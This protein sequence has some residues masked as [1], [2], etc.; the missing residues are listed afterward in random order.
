MLEQKDEIDDIDYNIKL[1]KERLIEKVPTHFSLQNVVDA[2]FA[3]LL[4]GLTFILKGALVRTALSLTSWHILAVVVFTF[5]IL[6]IQIYFISYQR[7]KNKEERSFGQFLF[8]R[9]ITITGVAL[10]VTLVLVFMLA[11]NIQ[12]GGLFNTFKVII[13]LWMACSIGSAIP[14]LLKKY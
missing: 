4:I 12:A 9:M 13:L 3:A 14:G 5:V 6:F 8:K 1:I 11:V 10:I 7:V 2:F